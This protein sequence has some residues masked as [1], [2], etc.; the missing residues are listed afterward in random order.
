M[1]TGM[2]KSSACL[3]IMAG[4]KYLNEVINFAC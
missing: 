2:Q 4:R 1:K 3:K